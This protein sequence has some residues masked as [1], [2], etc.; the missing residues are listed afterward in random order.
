[1][2]GPRS[3]TM[4]A[5]LSPFSSS[6]SKYSNSMCSGATTILPV[7]EALPVAQ[8]QAAGSPLP[9]CPIPRHRQ[10]GPVKKRQR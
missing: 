1:M 6:P 5:T 10:A 2:P 4:H 9:L 7:P 3:M 8:R